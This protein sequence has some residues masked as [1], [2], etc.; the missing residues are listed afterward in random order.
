MYNILDNHAAYNKFIVNNGYKITDQANSATIYKITMS[1]KRRLMQNTCFE[2][3]SEI[4][5]E[6][7]K[8]QEEITHNEILKLINDIEYYEHSK[9]S[10][11]VSLLEVNITLAFLFLK[12]PNKYKKIGINFLKNK[13]E[14]K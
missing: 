7:K 8:F 9:F 14:I 4:I 1:T 13:N 12:I 3:R 11:F 6:A 2:L 5:N 10:L